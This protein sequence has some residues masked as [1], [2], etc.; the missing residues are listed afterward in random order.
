MLRL[1]AAGLSN[2][3]VAARLFLSA[4][5]VSTHLTAIYGKLGV[6]GRSAAICAALDHGLR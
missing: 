5:T 2:P 6:D 3:E 4:R 1:V